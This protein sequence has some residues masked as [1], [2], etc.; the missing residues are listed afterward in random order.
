LE[1][2]P[3][4]LVII[5]FGICGFSIRGQL[6]ERIYREQ[7]GPPVLATAKNF[8]A[9]SKFNVLRARVKGLKSIFYRKLL[10]LKNFLS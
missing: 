10:K 6:A 9:N 7:R 1:P 3:L 8:L 2:I 5:G 4:F